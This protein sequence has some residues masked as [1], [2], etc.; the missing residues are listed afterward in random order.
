MLGTHLSIRSSFH[1]SLLIFFGFVPEKLRTIKTLVASWVRFVMGFS[2]CTYRWNIKTVTY[3]IRFN[4][5][6]LKIIMRMWYIKVEYMYV[7]YNHIH[8]AHI[9]LSFIERISPEDMY[10]CLKW[11]FFSVIKNKLNIWH[12]FM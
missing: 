8:I 11:V 7:F 1:S 3:A 12:R 5:V 6:F 9:P 4:W 2:I 10:V